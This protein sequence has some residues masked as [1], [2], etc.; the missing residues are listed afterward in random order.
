MAYGI[1][2][3]DRA[4]GAGPGASPAG[5]GSHEQAAVLSAVREDVRQ[6]LRTGWVDPALDTVAAHPVFFTAAWSAVR[7]NV[8]KTFLQVA[9]PLRS[10]AAEAIEA[11]GDISN[12]RKRLDGELSQEELRRVEEAA[13]A[14]HAATAKVQVVLA[15][16]FRAVHRE[17]IAG[18]G[19]EEPPIRRGVPDWQR[20]MSLPSEPPPKIL[21]EARTV[22]GMWPLPSALRLVARWPAAFTAVWHELVPRTRSDLWGPSAS[23]LRRTT[24]QGIRTLPHP[25]ELQWSALQ[26]RGFAEPERVELA[27]ALAAHD[28]A[29]AHHTL[30]AA[31]AW[32]AFGGPDMGAEG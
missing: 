5:L 2:A 6:T 13:R 19:R 4:T 26:E 28:A 17:R 24:L 27:E 20:W 11:S 16:L 30:A 25:V 32:L 15:M 31:F 3:S 21:D 10:Q 23:R 18:S 7:P 14:A 12:L 22:P 1:R 8:G 29:M 9:R